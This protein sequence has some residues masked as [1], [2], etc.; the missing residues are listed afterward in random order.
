MRYR[1]GKSF[2]LEALAPTPTP[3]PAPNGKVD[4]EEEIVGVEG[5][6]LKLNFPAADPE[7]SN[8]PAEIRVYLVPHDQSPPTSAE[9][10][11]SPAPF[12]FV[13][14]DVSAFAGVGGEVDVTLPEV[15]RLVPYHA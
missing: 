2:T 12:P 10:Y 4:V 1:L 5:N 6:I 13:T 7:T 8:F 11:L 14:V 9:G 3:E 15:D